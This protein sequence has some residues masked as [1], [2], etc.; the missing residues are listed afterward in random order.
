MAVK[1]PRARECETPPVRI[2]VVGHVE[3]VEFARVDHVPQAGEIVH[4]TETWEEAAR[5][6][7]VAAGQLARLGVETTLFPRL[8]NHELRRPR[9]PQ[10]AEQGVAGPGAVA[11]E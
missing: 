11:P 1:R 8:G 9:R 2:V 3:W 5:G 4:A 6:G 7:A 10:L